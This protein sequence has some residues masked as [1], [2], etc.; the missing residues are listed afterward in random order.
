MFDKSKVC[1]YM[2]CIPFHTTFNNLYT[3]L[4]RKWNASTWVFS[5]FVRKVLGS[6]EHAVC[7]CVAP[8]Y[9]MDWLIVCSMLKRVGERTLV[10][11]RH[12]MVCVLMCWKNLQITYQC[13]PISQGMQT[14]R[15]SMIIL[16]LVINYAEP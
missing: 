2:S 10:S 12:R 4:F 14:T 1:N 6:D 5:G 9:T 7:V 3:S 11:G 13:L 8:C 15:F 16:K